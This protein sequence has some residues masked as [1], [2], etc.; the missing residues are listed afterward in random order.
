MSNTDISVL[1]S[2]TSEK[3]SLKIV[4]YAIFFQFTLAESPVFYL[5]VLFFK[6]ISFY[7]SNWGKTKKN[8]NFGA[9]GKLVRRFVNIGMP[10]GDKG[11]GVGRGN[12]VGR[13]GAVITFQF[14]LLVERYYG[15]WC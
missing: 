9:L 4:K 8:E 15:D 6:N 3:K 13:L 11:M 7:V 1:V 5:D 12:S 14:R 10:S 2:V